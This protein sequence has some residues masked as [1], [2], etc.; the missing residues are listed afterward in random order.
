MTFAIAI[1][2]LNLPDGLCRLVGSGISFSRR[3]YVEIRKKRTVAV[4][5]NKFSKQLLANRYNSVRLSYF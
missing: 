5:E 2:F 1:C 4:E 3:I